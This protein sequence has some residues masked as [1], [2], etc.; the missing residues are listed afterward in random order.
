MTSQTWVAD[1]TLK[2]TVPRESIKHCVFHLAFLGISLEKVQL[3]YQDTQ[4][5]YLDVYLVKNSN[6]Q[7]YFAIWVSECPWE[8]LLQPSEPT[9]DCSP[10][11]HVET[12][13][14]I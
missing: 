9:D 5:V 7:H 1:W 6:I 11:W 3:L 2:F 14:R 8:Q 4:E 12:C 10:R 13:E